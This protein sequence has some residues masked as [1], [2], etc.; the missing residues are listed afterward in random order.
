[1]DRAGLLALLKENDRYALPFAVWPLARDPDFASLNRL[2]R[3]AVDTANVSAA[4]RVADNPTW[5][6]DGVVADGCVVAEIAEGTMEDEEVL[7][8]FDDFIEALGDV[9]GNVVPHREDGR[10]PDIDDWVGLPTS[11][12]AFMSFVPADREEWM[13]DTTPAIR[14][15]AEGLAAW[16]Y[17]VGGTAVID[18]AAVTSFVTQGRS[19]GEELRTSFDLDPQHSLW[20][21]TIRPRRLHRVEFDFGAAGI[22]QIVDETRVPADC[23]PH[24]LDGLRTVAPYLLQ[25]RVRRASSANP[26]ELDVKFSEG[27]QPTAVEEAA[28]GPSYIHLL[29]E[30]LIDPFVA[31]VVT[32]AHLKKI[33][34]PD[35]FDVED[36]GGGRH[37]VVASDPE[38]W[39]AGRTPDPRVLEA[40]RRAFAPALLTPEILAANRRMRPV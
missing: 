30:Y 11:L 36:L 40:A 39:L 38:P 27:R 8:W 17:L 21:V 24:L 14:E 23:L 28:M 7:A 33:G 16:S 2:V 15:A 4:R 3:T 6:R 29:D 1:M 10:V 25:A 35:G 5:C 37:L 32:D 12:T 9:E 22:L 13:W 18:R 20:Q 26:T 34:R 19:A 31:Q